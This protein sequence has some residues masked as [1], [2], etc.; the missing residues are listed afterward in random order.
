MSEIINIT[1]DY[2]EVFPSSLEDRIEARVRCAMRMIDG[3]MSDNAILRRLNRYGEL[4]IEC[5]RYRSDP[6]QDGC[7]A[8]RYIDA[9]VLYI[10]YSRIAEARGLPTG[11]EAAT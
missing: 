9:L 8:E 2:A 1:P 5:S 3:N 4:M 10:A 7:G 6:Y 11:G